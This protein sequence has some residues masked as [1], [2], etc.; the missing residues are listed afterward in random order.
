MKYPDWMRFTLAVILLGS[1]AAPAAAQDVS[2]SNDEKVTGPAADYPVV[3]GEPFIIDGETFTP[4]DTLNYDRVGY[5]SMDDGDTTGVTGSHKTLPLPS[6]IEVTALDSGRS[7]L[8][9]LERR[10]PMDVKHILGLSP[11]AMTQLAIQ[12]GAAIR[13]RR[14]NPPEEQRADLRA[15]GEAPLRMTVPEGLLV[16][17]RRRLPE[18]ILKGVEDEKQTAVGTETP[19]ATTM[20]TIDPDVEQVSTEA[21][22]QE[23]EAN[24][25]LAAEVEGTID[26]GAPAA[27]Q[28]EK[29]TGL[30][31]QL[32]AFASLDKA[33][34]LA[35]RV[36]GFVT[37]SGSL[38]LVRTGPFPSREKARQALAKLRSEGYSDALIQTID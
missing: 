25:P 32:G 15:G 28:P 12:D 36:D 13:M 34:D 27:S 18:P 11:A 17:L 38:H 19:P 2:P 31:V 37:R 1:L 21:R 23:L 16:A 22:V 5:A 3:I 14:V 26:R 35:A 29:P 24:V 7:I 10:G 8:V 20:A 4:V 33:Q 30:I 9:R 6:Y